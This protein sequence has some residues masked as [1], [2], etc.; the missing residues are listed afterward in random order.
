M[1]TAWTENLK[2]QEER[3]RFQDGLKHSKWL[4]SRMTEL[5]DKIQRGILQTERSPKN[6]DKPNWQYRQ[7]HAN[8]YLQCL[9]DIKSLINLDPKEPHDR[10]ST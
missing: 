10:Q 5:L 7:A 2:T 4:F 8:G 6:Y 3:D 1:I 9:N